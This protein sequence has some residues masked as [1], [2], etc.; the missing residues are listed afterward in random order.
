MKKEEINTLLK[1]LKK[2]LKTKVYRRPDWD[3]KLLGGKIKKGYA[4]TNGWSASQEQ[5]YREAMKIIQQQTNPS[6]TTQKG[7]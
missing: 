4:F 1:V 6:P 2:H 3:V 5:G 7:K